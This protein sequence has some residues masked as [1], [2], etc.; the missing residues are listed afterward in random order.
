M[1][2]I[3]AQTQTD[4]GRGGGGDRK[5]ERKKEPVKKRSL[6]VH[7]FDDKSHYFLQKQ[8]LLA[9]LCCLICI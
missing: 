8:L 2:L 6:N 1:S 7:T 5:K 9:T 4:E 3:C